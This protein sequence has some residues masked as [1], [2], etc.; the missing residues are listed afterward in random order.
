MPFAAQV[1]GRPGLHHAGL[2]VAQGA[3]DIGLV[4]LGQHGAFAAGH[5]LGQQRRAVAAVAVDP[6]ENAAVGSVAGRGRGQRIFEAGTG[7]GC[8]LDLAVHH[9][10]KVAAALGVL[11]HGQP[12]HQFVVGHEAGVA[13]LVAQLFGQGAGVHVE[14]VDV[15]HRGVAVVE[16]DEDLV[17]VLVR[18]ADDLHAG[19]LERGQRR[20][21]AA[22]HVDAVEQ[23]ILVARLVL[24]VEQALAVAGPEILPDGAIGGAVIAWASSGLGL[25]RHPHVEHAVARRQPTQPLAVGTDLAAGP[26]RVAEQVVA[27]DQREIGKA[28]GHGILSG[29][30]GPDMRRDGASWSGCKLCCMP[31]TRSRQAGAKRPRRR[32]TK[33]TGVTRSRV[34]QNRCISTA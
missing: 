3:A 15:E 5:V 17:L 33:F 4:V 16:A 11:T 1:I 6:V 21:L 25:G 18:A 12:Q 14:Q 9:L 23:E 8:V 31:N 30:G 26:G 10:E 20:L 32:V 22:R 7:E 13:V 27:R 29:L 2:G 24:H 19:V 34:H 28:L